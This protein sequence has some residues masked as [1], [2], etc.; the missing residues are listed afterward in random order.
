M[1][2]SHLSSLALCAI[3]ASF[4]CSVNATTTASV[5]LSQS[6]LSAAPHG[7]IYL[8]HNATFG[9]DFPDINLTSGTAYPGSGDGT[10]HFAVAGVNI[11]DNSINMEL[12]SVNNNSPAMDGSSPAMLYRNHK[13]PYDLAYTTCNGTKPAGASPYISWATGNTTNLTL[14]ANQYDTSNR[15]CGAGAKFTVSIPTILTSGP[16]G[17]DNLPAATYKSDLKITVSEN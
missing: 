10:F 7:E 13:I 6:V 16:N 12:K 2:N 9:A 1:I 3:I 5:S 8:F 17:T 4:A 14:T 15:D 11:H